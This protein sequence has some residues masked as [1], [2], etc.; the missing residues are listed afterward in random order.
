VIVLDASA[1]V[2]LV[3]GLPRALTVAA[4]LRAVDQTLHAPHLLSAEVAQVVRRF[5]RRGHVGA[6]RGAEAL[7][8]YVDMDIEYYDHVPFMDRVW[9]L[10]ANL[11]AYDALYVALAEA[12][13]AP[14]LT[15]DSR[16]RKAPGHRAEIEVVEG[17]ETAFTDV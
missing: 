5:E 13:D 2:E 14:L 15:T 1:V 16:L 6:N 4:R 11:T 17:G 7:T 10:R 3:L 9:Q 8:D 12:L